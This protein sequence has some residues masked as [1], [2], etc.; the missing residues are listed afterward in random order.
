M[1]PL[2]IASSLAELTPIGLAELIDRAALQTRVDRKYLVPVD[3]LPYLLDRLAPYARVLDIDGE[4]AFRYESVY[5]DTPWLDSYHCAAYRRRRRFKVRTRTYLDSDQ[6]WLEVKISGARGS[7]TKHRLPYRP[8]DRGTVDPGRGFVDETLTRESI[9]PTA[10]AVLEPMLVSTYHRTTLLLPDS[11]SRVTI[12]TGIRW[13]DGRATLQLP[14]LAVVETKTRSAA[15]P[16]DRLLWQGGTRPA[17]IS[18]YATGLAALRLDLPSVPWRRTM[19]R[20][21]H[22]A[23]S[24]TGPTPTLIHHLDQE[25]SCV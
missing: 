17:R 6:C 8:E 18:K 14:D 1:N 13:H 7:I 21:F 25:A 11:A 2:P 22:G 16:V 12:D 10:P 5:F 9:C 24:S 3:E 15:S 4:R 19:R 23:A 20:H